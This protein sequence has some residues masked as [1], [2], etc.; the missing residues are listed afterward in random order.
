MLSSDAGRRVRRQSFHFTCNLE[1]LEGRELLSGGGADS[2]VGAIAIPRELADRPAAI[3]PIAGDDALRAFDSSSVHRTAPGSTDVLLAFRDNTQY[4]DRSAAHGLAAPGE[5]AGQI[6]SGGIGGFGLSSGSRGTSDPASF[7]PGGLLQGT[8]NSDTVAE[9][10]GA[11]KGAGGG[12]SDILSRD[13]DAFSAGGA[14]SANPSSDAVSKT[15]GPGGTDGGIDPGRFAMYRNVVGTAIVAAIT[16]VAVRA[17][18]S[19]KGTGSQRPARPAGSG[20][21]RQD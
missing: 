12:L 5:K 14:D 10:G 8:R 18:R 15:M 7:A 16:I 19:H 3:G 13:A 4:R 11:A 17:A 21:T 2:G 6:G 20:N 9:P 1:R